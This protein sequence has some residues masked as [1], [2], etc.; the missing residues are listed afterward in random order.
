M[1]DAERG[2]LEARDLAV[3]RVGHRVHAGRQLAAGAARC[4]TTSACSANE[5]SI[6]DARVALAGG[7]V[8]D[9]PRGEQ[10]QPPAVGQ[11]VLL[12]ERAHR[13]RPVAAGRAQRVEVDLD[14]EVAGVGQHRA[15]L[16]AREVLGAEHAAARRS[17]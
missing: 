14:V 5:R 10:V 8:D 13:A 9:A 17:R 2:E 6:T 1:L 11:V 15:V 7:E 3:D 12:D 16:H 4:S